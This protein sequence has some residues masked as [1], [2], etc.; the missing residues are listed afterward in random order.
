MPT[1]Q[2]DIQKE[3]VSQVWQASGIGK[4]L[5]ACHLTV[6]K[7]RDRGAFVPHDCTGEEKAGYHQ[8]G[9]QLIQNYNAYV[10]SYVHLRDYEQW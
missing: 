7:I 9:V 1:P 2:E 3:E 8:E 6:N 10:K 5:D 4:L